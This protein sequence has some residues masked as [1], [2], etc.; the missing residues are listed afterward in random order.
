MEEPIDVSR[1]SL[2][3]MLITDLKEVLKIERQSFSSPWSFESFKKELIEN[4]FARYLVLKREEEIIGY[5]GVWIFLTEAHIT[6]LAI[7]PA[8]R[9]QGL[10]KYLLD[11]F[12]INFLAPRISEVTLEVR[13]SN[14][15]ARKLYLDYGFEEL[16]IKKDYYQDNQEDAVI[17]H[18]VLDKEL[19]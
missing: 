15:A 19:D 9:R 17:M 5:I 7:D 6:N 4:Q 12:F 16:G 11:K 1:L 14:Q 3:S 18:K 13:E 8:Y 2:R 10:A